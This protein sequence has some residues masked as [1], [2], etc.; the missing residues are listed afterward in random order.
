M[1]DLSRPILGLD[2]EYGIEQSQQEIDRDYWQQL[3]E[4]QV[5]VPEA[6]KIARETIP[7]LQF[8]PPAPKSPIGL[9]R[10]LAAYAR[11]LFFTEARCYPSDPRLRHWL[12]ALS[13]RSMK[14]VFDTVAQLE[15]SR[16]R[17]L[18]LSHHGLT[19]SQMREAMRTVLGSAIEDEIKNRVV[20][21]AKAEIK[22]R[23]V[24]STQRVLAA[25][26]E[27]IPKVKQVEPKDLAKK[28]K[29]YIEPILTDKGWSIL[30]W[31]NEA[32]VAY[33]T[34]AD[35]LTGSKNPY[36]STRVKLARAL[37][38]TANQLP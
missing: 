31:A 24:E 2:V 10:V 33:H 9:R 27:P 6:D 19:L 32:N 26:P 21:A 28:R 7:A 11:A 23:L 15:D 14:R 18:S 37:G 4:L 36:R 25:A 17:M 20:D 12:R 38:V 3:G 13:E 8:R 29:Q 30:D 1:S 22:A 35:Y 5:L 34:A 16:G